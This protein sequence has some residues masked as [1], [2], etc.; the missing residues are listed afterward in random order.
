MNDENSVDF[1]KK[2]YNLVPNRRSEKRQKKTLKILS[3]FLAF[4]ALGGVVFSYN[5][6]KIAVAPASDDG[7]FSI[8]SSFRRLVTS[9]EKELVGE[10]DDRINFLLMGIGGAGHDGPELTDTLMFASF[11]PSTNEIGVMSIPRDLVVPIPGYGYRKINHVNAYGELDDPGSGPDFAGD[12]VGG[13]IDQEIQYTIKVDFRGF[14]DLVNAIGGINVYVDRSFIDPSYPTDDYLTQVI[15]FEQGWQSMDGETALQF[16]RSRHGTNGEGDDF[17][18]AARQQKI[19]LAVKDK[20]LSPSV[21]LSPGKLNSLI[22]TFQDNVETNLS[23]WE[24]IKLARYAPDV[25]TEGLSLHVL[26][27]STE[28]PLYSTSING[29]Y[30][31]LPKQDDWSEVQYMAENVFSEAGTT[32]AQLAEQATPIELVT[33]EIQNGTS[34]NGLAFQTSQLLASS[35]V[36][37][38]KIGNAESRSYDTTIIYDLTGGKKSEGLNVLKDFLEADVAMSTTGWIFSDEVVPRELTVGTPGEDLTTAGENI[39]FLII[40]GENT[41]DLVMR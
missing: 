19:L 30:V 35:G 2:K 5:I 13:I 7:G 18:R 8:F 1:L 32:Q 15:G 12:V 22:E 3:V 6:S 21:L 11:R 4:V 34:V 16:A 41:A 20:V 25:D 10:E 29:A 27:G 37:V 40:L 31:L 28:S 17:A 39:D 24:M 38:V 14:E 9:D 26:D 36:N 23:F 33:V